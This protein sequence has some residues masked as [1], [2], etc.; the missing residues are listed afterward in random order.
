MRKGFDTLVKAVRT[1]LESDPLGGHLFV[2]RSRD[3]HRIKILWWDQNGYC[4]WATHCHETEK[5]IVQYAWHPLRGQELLV[6]I[7]SKHSSPIARCLIPSELHRPALEM[8]AW[9]LDAVRCAQMSLASEPRVSWH[10]LPE[11]RQLL[12]E[13]KPPSS[14]SR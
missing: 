6:A 5:R 7:F 12:R 13:A 14:A 8:L 11:L 10:A 1:V 3:G 9:I 4:I 2:F